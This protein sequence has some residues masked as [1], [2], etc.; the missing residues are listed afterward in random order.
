L[1]EVEDY[2]DM[3]SRFNDINEVIE[4]RALK[5]SKKDFKVVKIDKQSMKKLGAGNFGEVYLFKDI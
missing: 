4:R 3:L 1:I 5:L 2:K